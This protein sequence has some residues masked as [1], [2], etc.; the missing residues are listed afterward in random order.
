MKYV[1]EMTKM[2]DELNKVINEDWVNR[3]FNF[4]RA[5]RMEAAEAMDSL[6]WPW[7]KTQKLDLDNLKIETIDML[8][9]A[10]SDAIVKKL[11][12]TKECNT[13]VWSNIGVVSS[14]KLLM[15]KLDE[16]VA[17]TFLSPYSCLKDIFMLC[18]M[19]GMTEDDVYKLYLGKNVLNKF[20]TDNKYKESTYTK[21]WSS[22]GKL[23]EDNVVMLK[24]LDDLEITPTFKEDLYEKLVFNYAVSIG[25]KL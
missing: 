23:V 22:K 20:R 19:L 12:L 11:C 24:L 4:A 1:E 14:Q 8:H 17:S 10:L 13:R 6:D 2:Q 25:E 21:L 15:D 5:C 7:W 16:V 18:S 9:F 3:G